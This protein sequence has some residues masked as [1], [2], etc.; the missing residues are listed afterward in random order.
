MTN[1]EMLTVVVFESAANYTDLADANRVEIETCAE[2]GEEMDSL[3]VSGPD[4]VAVEACAMTIQRA[5]RDAGVQ[6]T[7]ERTADT[8]GVLCTCYVW[9]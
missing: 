8:S 1:T 5:L 6:A 3:L 2:A 7:A 9:V 4:A